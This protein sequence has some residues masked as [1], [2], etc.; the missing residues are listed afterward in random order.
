MWKVAPRSWFWGLTAVLNRPR[1]PAVLRRRI[2]A[3]RTGDDYKLVILPP[4]WP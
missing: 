3:L 1:L 4:P 2:Y